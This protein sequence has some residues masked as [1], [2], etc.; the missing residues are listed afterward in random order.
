MYPQ[1]D[2]LKITLNSNEIYLATRNLNATWIEVIRG[3]A[4]WLQSNSKSQLAMIPCNVSAY[5]KCC[6]LCATKSKH[7]QI[8]VKLCEFLLLQQ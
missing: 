3:L 7:V 2:G 5:K 4:S 6:T 8:T 1:G